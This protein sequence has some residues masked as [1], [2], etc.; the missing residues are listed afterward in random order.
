MSVSEAM[1]VDGE[2]SESEEENS[3]EENITSLKRLIKDKHMK[4]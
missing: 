4:I 3:E 1:V 2:A